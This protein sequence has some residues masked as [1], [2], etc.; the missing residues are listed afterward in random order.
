MSQGNGY[1]QPSHDTVL[2]LESPTR[3]KMGHSQTLYPPATLDSSRFGWPPSATNRFKSSTTTMHLL[4]PSVGF[5]TKSPVLY[6]KTSISGMFD[7]IQQTYMN[8]YIPKSNVHH[9]TQPSSLASPKSQKSR[10]VHSSLDC[11]GQ[12]HHVG[13]FFMVQSTFLVVEAPF[14]RHF[15]HH[16]APVACGFSPCG[17][18]SARGPDGVA[19]KAMTSLAKRPTSEMGN[20]YGTKRP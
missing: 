19:S 5:W 20:C 15:Q 12:I 8:L 10:S 7:F 9:N 14:P 3:S 4:N 6:R 11:D 1:Q 2:F 18:G 13:C 17:A 16:R